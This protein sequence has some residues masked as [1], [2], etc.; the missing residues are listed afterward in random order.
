[1]TVYN[2]I[3]KFR[4]PYQVLF[5]AD[6]AIIAVTQKMEVHKRFSAV[7]GGAVKPMITQCS[8]SHLVKLA[9]EGSQVAQEAVDLARNICE[10]RKCNHWKTKSSSVECIKGILGDSENRLHYL[11]CTQD[12][13]FRKYLRENIVGVPIIYLNRSGTL[14]LE[15]EGPASELRR[16]QLEEDKLHVP[17][18]E[19]EQLE[20]TTTG[21]QS[22]LQVQLIQSSAQSTSDKPQPALPEASQTSSAQKLENKLMKKKR[23]KKGGPNPLSVKKKK[24]SMTNKQRGRQAKP[25]PKTTPA[26]NKN[27]IKLSH[28][29]YPKFT[30]GIQESAG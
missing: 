21:L 25:T 1:M 29:K 28:Q 12:A 11:V 24:S 20:S 4:E 13:D 5:D 8:I 17:R 15:E 27:S 19:L 10:R 18:E 30:S 6:F 16:K 2:S 22:S 26:Q 3:F 9:S 23:R 14:L 7:L